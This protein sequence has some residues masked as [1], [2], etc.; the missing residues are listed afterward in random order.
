MKQHLLILSS[1]CLLLSLNAQ[2]NRTRETGGVPPAPRA[3]VIQSHAFN[4]SFD[5]DARQKFL[6]LAA[7]HVAQDR[8]VAL[9]QRAQNQDAERTYL[10]I[11]YRT[12]QESLLASKE[13]KQALAGSTTTE[14][15]QNGGCD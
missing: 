11:E 13:F 9:T 14:V 5:A 7:Q 10:C 8:V 2:A 4:G 15:V 12:Y 6:N 1:T 3:V